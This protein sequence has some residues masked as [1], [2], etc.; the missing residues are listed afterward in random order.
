MDLGLREKVALVLAASKGLGRA[1]AYALA[2]EGAYITIGARNQQMLEETAQHIRQETE[3]HVLAVPTDVRKAEDLEAIVAATLQTYGRLDI[4]VNNAGGPPPGQFEQFDDT[5]WQ[6]AFEINFL[7][8]V[9]AI[10]LVLPHMRQVGGGRIINIVSS[11]VKEPID[12]L[13]LSNAIRPGVV[14]LAKTLSREL[15][16]DN[17]TINNVCPGRI[18]TDR[19]RTGQ[20]YQRLQAQGKSEDEIARELAQDIPMKRIGKPEELGALVAFL[21][22]EQAA[23]I[24]GTTI[25]VDGGLVKSLL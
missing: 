19:I 24:T 2:A 5:A 17:I 13:I 15:A 23:Y 4:L 18:L 12:G 25:Q 16:A 9:H 11:S 21:A 22:S 14:G 7:S 8:A 10:R 20:A 3:S 6:S 1:S